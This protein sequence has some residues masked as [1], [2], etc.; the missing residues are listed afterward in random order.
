MFKEEVIETKNRITIKVRNTKIRKHFFQKK[1]IYRENIERLIPESLKEKVILISQPIK[2]IANFKS[3]NTDLEGEWVYKVVLSDSSIK[4]TSNSNQKRKRTT[5]P[6]TTRS[7]AQTT[8]S[9]STKQKKES[10]EKI[11]K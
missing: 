11:E 7:R 1:E 3:E 10:T 6:R 2:N 4:S 9:T 8:R 5:K